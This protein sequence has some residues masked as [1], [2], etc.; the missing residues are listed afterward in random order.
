M[1][2][3]ITLVVIALLAWFVNAVIPMEPRLKNIVN[4]VI[5]LI[6]VLYIIKVLF[7]ITIPGIHTPS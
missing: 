3:I 2:F 4:A 5:I 1:T 7:G 6:V